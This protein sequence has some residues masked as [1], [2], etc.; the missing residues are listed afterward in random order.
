M[1]DQ[2]PA[3]QWNPHRSAMV[4]PHSRGRDCLRVSA[5]L[6]PMRLR[7]VTRRA[8]DLGLLQQEQQMD[9]KNLVIV[10]LAIAVAV[11]GYLY[12][13]SQQQ[14]VV[15]DLPNLKIEAK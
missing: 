5:L 9:P 15:V 11:L 8:Q 10:V 6:L 12:Y 7:Y 4:Q 2:N 1:S 14:R 3:Q 13:D